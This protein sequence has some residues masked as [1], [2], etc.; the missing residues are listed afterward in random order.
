MKSG[1]FRHVERLAVEDFVLEEDHRIG[2]AD[3]GLEQALG[4]GG[5]PWCQDAAA[6]T[7]G[8]PTGVA[9]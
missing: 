2:I 1:F 7:V 5:A 3:R 4:V 6:G 9:L 8:V